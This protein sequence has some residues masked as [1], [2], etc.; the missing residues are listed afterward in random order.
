MHIFPDMQEKGMQKTC[1][2]MQE[3]DKKDNTWVRGTGGGQNAGMNGEIE[4]RGRVIVDRPDVIWID[5][6]GQEVLYTSVN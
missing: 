4:A 6:W 1:K 3:M 2:D 5:M